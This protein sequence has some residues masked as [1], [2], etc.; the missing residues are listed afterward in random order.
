MIY[1]LKEVKEEELVNFLLNPFE[2]VFYFNDLLIQKFPREPL[3]DDFFMSN[4]LL[5]N[6]QK[7]G[8]ILYGKELVMINHPNFLSQSI[9]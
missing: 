2:R 8:H 5:N 3:L 7:V 6:C 9:W 1:C 4:T